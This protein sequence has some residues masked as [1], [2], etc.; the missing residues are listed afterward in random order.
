[1]KLALGPVELLGC[2]TTVRLLERGICRAGMIAYDILPVPKPRM[3]QR[4]RWRKRPC[5]LRYRA[6][7]DLVRFARIALPLSYH[8]TFVLPTTDPRLWGESHDRTPDRDNLEKAFLDAWTSDDRR[9]A[10]ALVHKVWGERG[11]IIV[12]EL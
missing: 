2:R 4:D 11:M 7:C 1:M 9:Y 6:F 8:V 12:G 5:V 10:S 3:T